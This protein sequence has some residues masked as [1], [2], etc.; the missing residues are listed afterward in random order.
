MQTCIPPLPNSEHPPGFPPRVLD[1]TA[2]EPLA[3]SS[4]EG[5]EPEPDFDE[6]S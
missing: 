5:E 3:N 2:G 4:F 6:R 1:D